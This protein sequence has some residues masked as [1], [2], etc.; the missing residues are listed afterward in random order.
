MQPQPLT[1][2]TSYEIPRNAGDKLIS[3]IDTPASAT[4]AKS[5]KLVPGIDTPNPNDYEDRRESG[6]GFPKSRLSNNMLSSS[7]EEVSPVRDVKGGASI[8]DDM[9]EVKI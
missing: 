6:A 7:D 2:D 5:E 1:V 9:K 8:E 4:A 3:G